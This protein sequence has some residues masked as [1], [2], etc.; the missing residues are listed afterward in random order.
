MIGESQVESNVGGGDAPLHV[1]VAII[2]AG[3]AG[4]AAYRAAARVTDR[5]V[6]IEGGAG[7]TTCARMA[8]MPSKLLV[9]A[10]DAAHAVSKAHGFGIG[11]AVVHANVHGVRVMERIRAERDR[12]VGLVNESAGT[13]PPGHR[14]QGHAEFLSSSSVLVG[15][16]T[17]RANAFVL[18]T[19][20]RPTRHEMFAGLGDR[21]IVSDDLFELP[22]LPGS[23]AVFGAGSVGLE[24]GQALHRLGVRVRLFGQDGGLG[25]LTDPTIREEAQR[26]IGAELP[27]DTQAEVESIKRVGRQVEL[28]FL[29]AGARVTERFDYLLAATGRVPNVDH[30][31]LEHSGLALD[32][33]GVP[34]FDRA[35]L[36]CGTSSIFI[37]GDAD[38]DVPVLHEAFAEGT[39]AGD[40]AARFP[41]V[42]RVARLTPMAI[43]FSYPQI[44]MVGERWEAV[45]DRG[46]VVGEV[47]FEDQGRSRIMM[48]NQGRL[49]IYADRANARFLGAEMVGPSAEHLAHLLAW[50]HQLGLTVHE[51]LRLPIY[52]PVVEEVL[53]TAL[54]RAAMQFTL[55]PPVGPEPRRA[56]PS[57]AAVVAS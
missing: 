52:H 38:I 49:H 23:V 42:Q 11:D 26:I 16:V 7:G 48:A 1:D 22:D 54:R 35:T 19:G 50:A 32:S 43:V 28:T 21:L 9:A 25:P 39:I 31:G 12:F 3:T 24:L 4:L 15:A 30:L 37:A 33:G 6:L 5:L 18:A 45:R 27:L 53:R 13:I 10:A 8:C 46:V 56:G 17:V 29:C 41:N 57:H 34:C 36:R 20:S 14:L 2:G 51:M 40:N 44:A 47:S 55:P